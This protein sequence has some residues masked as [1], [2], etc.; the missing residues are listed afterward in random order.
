VH[1]H[2]DVAEPRAKRRTEI[3]PVPCHVGGVDRSTQRTESLRVLLASLAPVPRDW[4]VLGDGL[5]GRS[6]SRLAHR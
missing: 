1:E 5:Q 6:K 2:I 4:P 3:G